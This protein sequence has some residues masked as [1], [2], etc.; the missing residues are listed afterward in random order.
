MCI[1]ANALNPDVARI[2]KG[3]L[4]ELRDQGAELVDYTF[5]TANMP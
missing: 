4:H 1:A 2:V 5:P 3:K